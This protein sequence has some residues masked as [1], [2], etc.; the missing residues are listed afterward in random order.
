MARIY[1]VMDNTKDNNT[2]SNAYSINYFNI[3]L[4]LAEKKSYPQTYKKMKEYITL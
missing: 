4:F 3:P 1:G 2:L